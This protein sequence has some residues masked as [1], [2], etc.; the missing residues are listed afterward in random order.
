MS[1]GDCIYAVLFIRSFRI[2]KVPVWYV[3]EIVIKGCPYKTEP[4]C[5]CGARRKGASAA[6]DKDIL[7][8]LSRPRRRRQRERHRTKDLMRAMAV[9]VRYASFY[10][11]L[12]KLPVVLRSPA[13]ECE[14][15]RLIFRI[16]MWNLTLSLY[17]SLSTFLEALM[18]RTV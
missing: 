5:S 12:C 6:I 4:T 17:I 13:G 8:S 18:F 16:F 11:H 7:E 14:R 10:A 9:H 15:W 3:K 2:N 1:T